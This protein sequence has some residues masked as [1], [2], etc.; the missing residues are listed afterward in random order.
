MKS[1]LK[2]QYHAGFAM[3]RQCI[4]RCPDD[5]WSQNCPEHPRT[6]WRIAYH[7]IYYTHLY[8]MT[9]FEDFQP[10][11]KHV[12]HGPVLWDD[13]DEG[14]PPVETSLTQA[15]LIEYLDWSDAQVDAW[16]DQMDLDSPESGFYWYKT[17]N[18]MDHQV[19]NIRHLGIHIGQLQELLY[20]RGIDLDWVTRR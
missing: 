5:L 7:A 18:K 1:A 11:D 17:V 13:D 14:I 20:A 10:W 8:L 16:L 4:E 19:L 6:F 12:P 3:L 15:G 9:K 2:C